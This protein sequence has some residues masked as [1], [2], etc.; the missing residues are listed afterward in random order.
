MAKPKNSGQ[1]CPF[2][3]KA[4]TNLAAHV[5]RNHDVDDLHSSEE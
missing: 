5:R 4:V 1:K 2:C 3:A